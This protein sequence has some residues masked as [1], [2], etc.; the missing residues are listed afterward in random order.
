MRNRFFSLYFFI[1][2]ISPISSLFIAIKT[3]SG[4][5]K[6]Y[7]L[8]LLVTIFGSNMVLNESSDS[9]HHQYSVYT[10][11]YGLSFGEY[12]YGVERI[13]TFDRLKETNE[14]IYIHT[15]SYISGGFLGIPKL[16][17]TMVA[18]GF[19]FFFISGLEK[20]FKYR[21]FYSN[22][23]FYFF[24]IVL[25]VSILFVDNMQTVRTWTGAWVLFNGVFGFI[26]SRKGKYLILIALT[27]MIHFAYLLMAIPALA[28]FFLR[29]IESRI[30]II[31]YFLS[32]M[33]TLISPQVILSRLSSFDLGERK[34]NSYYKNPDELDSVSDFSVLDE[35]NWYTK[36][37]KVL[38][39]NYGCQS[40]I[41]SFFLLGF[42]SKEKMTNLE[43]NL[44]SLGILFV[45][46]AN[47][48]SFIPAVNNRTM[49]NAVL[50]IC[51]SV[52]LF[53]IRGAFQ[54]EKGRFLVFNQNTLMAI[55]L[56]IFLPHFFYRLSNTLQFASI[57][58]LFFP[59]LYWISPESNM[60]IREF[61]GLFI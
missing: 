24:V 2:F 31:I 23:F 45:I 44:F 36:Y 60:S 33:F 8:I 29:Y 39:K 15:L 52:T 55:S 32:F 57:G 26:E 40:L 16:F 43:F 35:R 11:Y 49:A 13:L 6:K 54:F 17:F 53:F 41:I 28:I 25:F 59:F 38:S 30:L 9:F 34:V 37:G 14:D 10:Y 50:Y 4:W 5:Q 18:F 61:I 51:A 12:L 22:S 47:I 21:S 48:F 46:W 7:I 42:F 20:V 56:I 1:S 58:N 27:P 19:G 3:L